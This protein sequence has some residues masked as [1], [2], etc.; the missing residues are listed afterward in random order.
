MC[1]NCRLVV[2]FR[3]KNKGPR[4]K[5]KVKKYEIEKKCL[6][7]TASSKKRKVSE[8]Q[9]L[10][11]RGHGGQ[12]RGEIP[13]DI[14]SIND[15]LN[16]ASRSS[17]PTTSLREETIL[18]DDHL[19]EYE[20]LVRMCGETAADTS[21]PG[22]KKEAPSM[23]RKMRH[24]LDPH[25]RMEV[26]FEEA[27]KDL[28]NLL[29]FW[30]AGDPAGTRA[31]I[32]DTRY[33]DDIYSA[34]K[35]FSCAEQE[36]KQIQIEYIEHFGDDGNHM[37]HLLC[38]L[39]GERDKRCLPYVNMCLRAWLPKL[40]EDLELWCDWSPLDFDTWVAEEMKGASKNC[41][42]GRTSYEL[43]MAVFGG[44]ETDRCGK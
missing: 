29:A 17:R 14:T 36:A 25:V 13:E 28:S 30:V 22:V 32:P 3:Q 6:Q 43:M 18:N 33:R 42:Q 15:S 8:L 44:K 38:E 20:R 35:I 9:N 1:E 41:H 27:S 34:L 19:K 10:S 21:S 2:D 12:I 4:N 16:R 23:L 40:V 26:D 24:L 37:H 31:F 11:A 7:P 39:I 5:N